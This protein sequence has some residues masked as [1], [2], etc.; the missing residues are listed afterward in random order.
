MSPSAKTVCGFPTNSTML[1]WW[2]NAMPNRN[3][4]YFVNST[5]PKLLCW[6]SRTV[7]ETTK[8]CSGNYISGMATAIS[9]KWPAITNCQ[10]QRKYLPA[11]PVSWGNRTFIPRSP[12]VSNVRLAERK[13]FT[14]TSVG[15]SLRQLR[16]D[17]CTCLPSSMTTPDAS[18]DS[19][20]SF[21][22]SGWKS[23]PTLFCVWNRRLA[24]QTAFLGF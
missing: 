2:A 21:S 7:V 11:L 18:S 13:V 6:P 4:S 3:L 8:N 22:L 5:L 15:H 16:K 19:W 12:M 14:P 17:T 20:L 23:G 9:W 10:F 1:S 24:A